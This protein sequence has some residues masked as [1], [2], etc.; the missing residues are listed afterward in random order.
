MPNPKAHALARLGS[1][2]SLAGLIT[3]SA[4][5]ACV[6]TTGSA[7]VRFSAAASGPADAVAGAPYAFDTGRGYHVSLTRAKLHIGAL[8]LNRSVPT[9]GSQATAC[10][11]PGIY[12]GQLTGGGDV[13]VLSPAPQP[14]AGSGEGTADPAAVGEVWLTGGDVN[15]TSDSTV[16]LDVAGTATKGTV[17]FAFQGTLTIGQNRAIAPSDATMPG[18]NPICKQR[19]V[20]PIPVSLTPVDGGTLRV[21]IDPRG[22]FSNVD[23]ASLPATTDSPPTYVFSDDSSNAPSANLYLGL[24]AAEGV[25]RFSFE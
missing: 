17:S 6:G 5:S 22:W 2:L 20:S 18:A 24:H 21:V 15:A 12:V 14:L 1:A 4:T 9:S 16:I 19:I 13:D 23:F 8:Y 10:T 11:L 3:L 25:Y 7:L